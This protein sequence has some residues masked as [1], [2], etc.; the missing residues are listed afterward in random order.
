MSLVQ[1]GRYID[2][3]DEC[4]RVLLACEVKKIDVAV[5]LGG[6][7]SEVKSHLRH[8]E[9]TTFLDENWG[10]SVRS[11]QD[12]M[13]VAKF[14]EEKK[15]SGCVF[16]N[17]EYSAVLALA[18]KSV[19]Q[20][21]VD[22]AIEASKGKEITKAEASEI[23]KAHKPKPEPKPDSVPVAD[24]D[25]PIGDDDDFPIDDYEDVVDA[26]DFG[27]SDTAEYEEVEDDEPKSATRGVFVNV[28]DNSVAVVEFAKLF[29]YIEKL[30]GCDQDLFHEEY[31]ARYGTQQPPEG[32]D[33]LVSS[34]REIWDSASTKSRRD[35]KKAVAGWEVGG[36]PI[37]WDVAFDAFWNASHIKKGKAA[38]QKAF[39]TAVK[40]KA[41]EDDISLKEA[42]AYVIVA[43]ED[44]ADSREAK[45]TDHSPIHPA[46]WLNQARFDDDRAT[47]N[48]VGNGFTS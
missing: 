45:P 22:E 26:V 37:K 43:M 48:R 1:L 21:A 28:D 10:W 30:S 29:A 31:R 33:S 16:E 7:L 39:K 23:I 9:F 27:P 8:G 34:V 41:D 11:A 38:A 32:D 3:I 36:E 47:W 46:T 12:Y 42:A 44:F 4:R 18:S 5:K 6:L 20:E 17:I 24:D 13:K 35:I 19:P 15:R 14:V 25:F 40:R 2:E